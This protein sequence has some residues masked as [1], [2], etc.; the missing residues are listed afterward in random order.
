MSKFDNWAERP[1]KELPR[2]EL[3]CDRCG[4]GIIV[5]KRE[6]LEEQCPW[7]ANPHMAIYEKIN[8]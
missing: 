2:F 4:T 1:R 3:M 8:L 7:C 6:D 5:E